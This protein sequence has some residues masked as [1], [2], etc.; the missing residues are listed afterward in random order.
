MEVKLGGDYKFDFQTNLDKLFLVASLE[1]YDPSKV[2][3]HNSM[4][5]SV[6]LDERAR[7]RES[8]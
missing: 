7:S 1:G 2:T 6:Y 5:L 8:K 4:L 3:L